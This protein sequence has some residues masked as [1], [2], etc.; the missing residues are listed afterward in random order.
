MIVSKIGK[1]ASI[2]A[3]RKGFLKNT[4]FEIC[5]ERQNFFFVLWKEE[6]HWKG[7]EILGGKTD[8]A[9]L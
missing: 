7:R 3:I 9:K 8:G 5:F 2:Y 1:F 6:A 4:A